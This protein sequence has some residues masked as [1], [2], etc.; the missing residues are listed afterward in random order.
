MASCIQSRGPLL[1]KHQELADESMSNPTQSRGQEVSS[2]SGPKD[3][4]IA[5]R[6]N[7]CYSLGEINPKD[8]CENEANDSIINRIQTKY[9]V[10]TREKKIVPKKISLR[11]LR[12]KDNYDIDDES[13]SNCRDVN[14]LQEAADVS[15]M[16]KPKDSHI[17]DK[18][19]VRYSLGKESQKNYLEDGSNDSTCNSIQAKYPV[20]AR[21]KKILPKKKSLKTN[22]TSNSSIN[23]A[24]I[25][26]DYRVGEHDQKGTI[27]QIEQSEKEIDPPSSVRVR[28]KSLIKVPSAIEDHSKKSKDVMSKSILGVKALYLQEDV[29]YKDM[30]STLLGTINEDHNPTGSKCHRMIIFDHP[31]EASKQKLKYRRAKARIL[32]KQGVTVPTG[33]MFTYQDIA[34]ALAHRGL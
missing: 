34:S 28:S 13:K 25:T 15:S 4:H 19:N 32:R 2:M 16:S 1:T 14:K 22:S 10:V 9:P 18:D 8:C 3:S 33:N 20:K 21:A 29:L 24:S 26:N 27:H 12:I 30:V 5:E 7:M 11:N 17:A 6:G 31:Y 23:A